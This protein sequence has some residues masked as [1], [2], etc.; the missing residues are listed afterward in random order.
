MKNPNS[1]NDSI[2]EKSV[3]FYI[4]LQNTLFVNYDKIRRITKDF[5][6]EN[7][8]NYV[9]IKYLYKLLA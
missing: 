2:L 3:Q 4:Y 7:K 5:R 6:I 1:I 9:N 8:F